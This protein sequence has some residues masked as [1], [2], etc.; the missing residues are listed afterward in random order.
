MERIGPLLPATEAL[1]RY[2]RLK[3][4]LFEAATR[5]NGP[6]TAGTCSGIMDPNR[7]YGGTCSGVAA[8]AGNGGRY[9]SNASSNAARR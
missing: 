1:R 4:G 8:Y 6:A 7:L 5:Y 3:P 2:K 9:R